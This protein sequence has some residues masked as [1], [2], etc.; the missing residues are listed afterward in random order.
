MK[1][2]LEFAVTREMAGRSVRQFLL[3]VRVSIQQK[4]AAAAS[5]SSAVTQ[6]LTQT[7]LHL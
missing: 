1:R 2:R 5:H 3:C 6:M 7:A 4:A